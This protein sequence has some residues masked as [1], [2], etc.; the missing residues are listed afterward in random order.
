MVRQRGVFLALALG[1]LFCFTGREANAGNITIKISWD[2]T[3]FSFTF[4]SP[5]ASGDSNAN[6][7]NVADTATLNSDIAASGYEFSGLTASSNNPGS[8]G[9]SILKLTG[10]AELNGSVAPTTPL[11]VEAF[12]ADFTSPSGPG[13]LASQATANF[14]NALAGSS[15][16]SNGQLDAQPATPTL[17]FL[18]P[19]GSSTSS[20]GATG[21]PLG[22][23]LDAKVIITLVGPSGLS[24]ASDQFTNN[25]SFNVVPEPASLVMMV[26][27]MPLPLVV[28]GLLHRRRGRTA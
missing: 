21:N 27:G 6:F 22:Y 9:G 5:I 2:A 10:T 7:L 3:S 23:T 14:R 20:I 16:S 15:Q 25:V 19:V 1:A 24:G 18:P 28:M 11:T 13:T 8:P 17:T 4:T 12:Q 26:T